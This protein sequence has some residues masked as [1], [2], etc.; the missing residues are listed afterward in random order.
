MQF[1]G[2]SRFTLHSDQLAQQV[3]FTLN[4][5]PT[6]H[7]A[8]YVYGFLV[9]IRAYVHDLPGLNIE[10]QSDV[11]IGVG[12]SS[13]VA[14]E[15]ATLRCLRSLIGLTLDDVALAKLAQRAEIEYVGVHFGIMDQMVSS[16]A[17][18]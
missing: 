3:E 18:I 10:V 11:P 7:F 9:L 15:V 1:N 6:E 16:L 2:F 17:S 8:T 14:L 4:A 13:S 12:M 5:P